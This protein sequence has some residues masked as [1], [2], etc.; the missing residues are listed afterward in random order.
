M[1]T[2]HQKPAKSQPPPVVLSL[3]PGID[4][5]GRGFEAE[6]FCIVRGPDLIF[7]Q[8]VE[9]FHIPPQA[10]IGII[11]GPPCQSFSKANRTGQSGHD[12]DAS[13]AEFRRLV[14]EGEPDWWLVEN[15]PTVP[16][17]SIEGYTVQRLD[18]N[19]KECGLRQYRLRHFQFGYKDDC[20]LIPDRDAPAPPEAAGGHS[21][22]ST[23]NS[24]RRRGHS[25]T[26]HERT[27]LASEAT[28]IN[29]RSFQD[30][31]ELQG[32]PKDFDLPGWSLAFKYRAV[33][34]GV[35]I[36][37]ARVIARAIARRAQSRG[38]T[39]C[40]CGCGRR[41]TGTRQSALPACRKRRERRRKQKGGGR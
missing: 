25:T 31:C 30:F 8:R 39:L 27:C 18:L 15:V 26:G 6:G 29:R 36:P 22:D 16:D 5:L 3:F 23:T 38:A 19:A 1:Q 35:P 24:D 10:F 9:T 20:P 11:A 4:L 14:T 7:G 32:L 12:G 40:L 33:G 41:V 21:R 37:M 13:I 17:I 28:R 2:L 34:N